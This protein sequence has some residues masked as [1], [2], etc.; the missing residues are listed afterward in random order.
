MAYIVDNLPRGKKIFIL[1]NTKVANQLL[2]TITVQHAESVLLEN[3]VCTCNIIEM[4][5]KV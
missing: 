3:V 1:L 2:I 5:E 4:D